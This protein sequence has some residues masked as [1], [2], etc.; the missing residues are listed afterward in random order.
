MPPPA[1]RG[2]AAGVVLA[3]AWL[4]APAL[5]A[6]PEIAWEP[7]L[8]IATGDAERGPWRMNESRF[9]HV[10]DPTVAVDDAGGVAVA[11][12]DQ[13][14][15]NIY[16]QR[17]GPD[18]RPQLETP[19]D[20]S[21]SSNVFSWLPRLALA[22]ESG[23]LVYLLWQ[24]IVFSGGTHGGEI[25]F[26]RSSDG[27]RS[28][29]VPRNLSQTQAGAGKGRLSRHRWSNGSLDL[30]LGPRGEVYAAWTEYE[31][32]LRFSR[33]TDGGETFSAPLQLAG[34]ENLFPARGP[35]LAAGT[36][37]TIYL[38][39]TIGENARAGIHL[40][41]ST[42]GGRSFGAHQVVAA[43]PGHADAPQLAVSNAY[44]HLVY[45]ES[46]DGPLRRYRIR[47]ARARLEDD[48]S[49]FA[50]PVTIATGDDLASV[51]FPVL[52]PDGDDNLYVLWE[53]FPEAGGRPH[54]LGYATSGDDGASFSPAAVV[55][56]S[57]DPALGVN[58]SLQGLLMRKL[59]VDPAG[60]VAVVNSS[61]ADGVASRIRLYRG[62]RR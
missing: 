17:F 4:V 21:G 57:D 59:A 39:W 8:E 6:T 26:A 18:G 10:D 32:P 13:A 54:G 9:L 20:V 52:A 55:P 23:E 3:A 43:G 19:V 15:R 35:S 34:G 45:A 16:F 1:L 42:D 11:W 33:S 62:R 49:G 30:A 40:A 47:H 56:G 53:R 60:R 48:A 5:A 2:R 28:F 25:F 46:P 7:P 41:R 36:D 29:S 51:A 12:A 22:G 37:G 31:G 38:A 24:E 44:L 27:G 14:E 61:Y 50:T 58:G